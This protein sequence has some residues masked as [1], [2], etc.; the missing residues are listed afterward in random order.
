LSPQI[1]L[2]LTFPDSNPDVRIEPF[3]PVTTTVSYFIGNDPEQWRPAVPVWSGV[4]Y[5]DLYPGVDMMP[6]L[7]GPV[8]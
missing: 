7:L 1:A 6:L 8:H 5:V 4:R 3:D 2:K